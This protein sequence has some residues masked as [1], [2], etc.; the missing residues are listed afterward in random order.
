MLG[1]GVSREEFGRS[2]PDV[3]WLFTW[4]DVGYGKGNQLNDGVAMV[5]VGA[6]GLPK[7]WL[8][9]D[10]FMFMIRESC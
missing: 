4:V 6:L 1:Y 9:N 8:L 7:P 10:I 3:A 2:C 5:S